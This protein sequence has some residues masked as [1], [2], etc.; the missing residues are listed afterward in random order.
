MSK[1]VSIEIGKAKKWQ[2]IAK[3]SNQ[4]KVS[5][6]LGL[7]DREHNIQVTSYD[8][9]RISTSDKDRQAAPRSTLDAIMDERP[10]VWEARTDSSLITRDEQRARSKDR[11]NHFLLF[12]KSLMH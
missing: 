7:G 12:K 11:R 6:K 4:R 3:E 1:A 2:D 8:N 9:N 10:P 5:K